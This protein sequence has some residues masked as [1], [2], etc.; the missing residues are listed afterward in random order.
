MD[1]TNNFKFVS[2]IKHCNSALSS[3][4]PQTHAVNPFTVFIFLIKGAFHLVESTLSRRQFSLKRAT[5]T[6][7][8]FP[9]YPYYFFLL[10]HYHCIAFVLI[11][12]IWTL[13]PNVKQPKGKNSA[14]L[15][16]LNAKSLA[17]ASQLHNE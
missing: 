10:K 8:F 7:L 3:F 5:E 15:E 16:L 9:L 14:F 4:Y 6:L 2:S 12:Y 13:R 17:Y 1:R 11:L